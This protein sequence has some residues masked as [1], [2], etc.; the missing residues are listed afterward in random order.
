LDVQARYTYTPSLP[1]LVLPCLSLVA[2][3]NTEWFCKRFRSTRK[4][5]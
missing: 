1:S 2:F 5:K 3:L 4:T